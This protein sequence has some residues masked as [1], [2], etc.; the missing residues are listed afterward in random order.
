MQARRKPFRVETMDRVTGRA[1]SHANDHARGSHVYHDEI[2]SEL[3]TLRTL[4]KPAE[5]VSAT[6]VDAYKAQI[7]EA[8]KLKT[9]LDLIYDAINKTKQEI[10]TVHMTGFEGPEMSRVTNELDAIVGGTEHATEQILS[11]AEEIDQMATTLAARLKDEQNQA[12]VADIQERVIK[13]FEACNFQDLTG[14]R[15]TKVVSTLTFIETHIVRMMEIWGGLD[16]FKDIA[17]ETI[18]VPAGDARLLNGPKV[19]GDVGH[20]SQDDIDALFA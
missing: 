19:E 14:Q 2:M 6:M 4:V 12:L 10:A 18:A 11:N 8:Q 15:I 9:E 20:A 17:P 16:A 3:R 1:T 13:V 5:Q 7:A